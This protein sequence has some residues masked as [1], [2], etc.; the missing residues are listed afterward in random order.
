MEDVFLH[1][2]SLRSGGRGV[3]ESRTLGIMTV[4]EFVALEFFERVSKPYGRS[5]Q[6]P[7]SIANDPKPER[8]DRIVIK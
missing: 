1:V 8:L 4:G 3:H 5:V 6:R 2:A 7:P